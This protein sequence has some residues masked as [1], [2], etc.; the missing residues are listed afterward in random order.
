MIR[1]PV[2]APSALRRFIDSEAS[3]GY[4]L[5][6]ATALALISANSFLEVPYRNLAEA[7]LGGLSVETWVNDVLMP[8]FFL[9]IGLEIK[10]EFLHGRLRTWSSRTLPLI[11]AIGGMAVPALIFVG[12][13]WREPQALRGWAI[14]SATDIAFALGVLS[15]LGNRVPASL[16]VFLTTL[17][18]L[19]DL[20]AVA[21]I[22]L[23]YTGGLSAPVLG[24]AASTLLILVGFNR[25]GVRSLWP[26]LLLGTVL[27]MLIWHSG[28]HATVA[29]VLLAMTIP[30]DTSS[31]GP[32]RRGSPLHRLEHALE[33]WAAYAVLPMFAFVNAGVSVGAD[34]LKTAFSPIALGTGLGLWVGKQAGILIS[35]WLAVKFKFGQRPQGATWA[36][37][38]GVCLLCGIGFTMSLFIASLAYPGSPE[39]IHATKMGVLIGSALSAVSGAVV[40]FSSSR[41]QT[42]RA[43]E[44]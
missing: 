27:W 44:A 14:P 37:T 24:L 40:L 18:V 17:A 6:G 28:V 39:Q 12:F 22:A 1:R 33:P 13:N 11:G 38:Y 35:V 31:T 9:L 30:A 21:I 43:Q 34:G 3:G 19:D 41:R 10:R 36:Q 5:I 7:S 25:A 15:L 20:G 8:V 26:Y 16:K 29:G 32:E 4:L 42:G 23:F 2:H